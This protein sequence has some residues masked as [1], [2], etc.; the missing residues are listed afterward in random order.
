MATAQQFTQDRQALQAEELNIANKFKALVSPLG[1]RLRREIERLNI[2]GLTSIPFIPGNVDEKN[3]LD[4]L[5][6][7]FCDFDLIAE[8]HVCIDYDIL[9]SNLPENVKRQLVD[10]FEGEETM[11]AYINDEDGR[12]RF[13]DERYS[14]E[15]LCYTPLC[16]AFSCCVKA[17]Q[18][19]S[20]MDDVVENRALTGGEISALT[21]AYLIIATKQPIEISLEEV[22]QAAN[23]LD[24]D[25]KDE[26]FGKGSLQDYITYHIELH[27]LRKLP[28]KEL[29]KKLI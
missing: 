17:H 4:D 8:Q 7:L 27:A 18:E 10:D 1:S 23:G 9:V 5:D 19:G 24:N 2:P 26:L 6:E 13:R 22:L 25:G 21:A 12:E 15:D 3:F 20:L 11:S 29:L 28:V 16:Q 14:T